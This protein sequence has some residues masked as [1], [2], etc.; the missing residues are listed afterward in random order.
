MWHSTAHA[1]YHSETSLVGP[2]F[3]VSVACAEYYS[4]TAEASVCS[5]AGDYILSGCN[6]IVCTQP[7]STAGYLVE[8]ATATLTAKGFNVAVSCGT[9]YY[10]ESNPNAT[11]CAD[12]PASSDFTLS[13]CAPFSC[14]RPT[15]G[16]EGYTVV[17]ETSLVAL[18]FSVSLGCAVGHLGTATA[19]CQAMGPYQVS[20]CASFR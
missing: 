11:V 9:H 7:A 14:S 20:G 13:G 6:E 10:A 17:N 8:T 16:M 19:S 4:G 5:S 3:S 12:P 2:H 1:L 15:S 18:N